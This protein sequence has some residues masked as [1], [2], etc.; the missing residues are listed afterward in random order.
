[1]EPASAIKGRLFEAREVDGGKNLALTDETDGHVKH[2]TD[3]AQR[4]ET[5]G[6]QRFE[7]GGMS[8]DVFEMAA[9]EEIAAE[10]EARRST[11][12]S[13]EIGVP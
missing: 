13:K 8:V 1:M 9:L 6:S 3:G 4:Y 7:A 11:N 10:L 5:E 2:E 12:K